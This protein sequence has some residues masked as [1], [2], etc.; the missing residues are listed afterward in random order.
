MK[1]WG[2]VN[3]LYNTWHQ[4]ASLLSTRSSTVCPHLK[5]NRPEHLSFLHAIL[6]LNARKKVGTT[7][8]NKEENAMDKEDHLTEEEELQ[9]ATVQLSP[10][11]SWIHLAAF[12]TYEPYKHFTAN[13]LAQS[14]WTSPSILKAFHSSNSH[15][16]PLQNPCIH[17]FVL[18]KGPK[19][20]HFL[21]PRRLQARCV[22]QSIKCQEANEDKSV[23]AE[24]W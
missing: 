1:Q 9:R 23:N 19:P 18:G 14:S 16:F 24:Q 2:V 21:I 5:L 11:P 4:Q 10:H 15:S 22:L 8:Q 6:F 12:C 7:F 3:Y 17:V 20:P 13:A